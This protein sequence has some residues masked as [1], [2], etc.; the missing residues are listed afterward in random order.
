METVKFYDNKFYT[1]FYYK[2]IIDVSPY[3]WK[4]SRYAEVGVAG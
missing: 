1:K 2:S 4:I 3:M